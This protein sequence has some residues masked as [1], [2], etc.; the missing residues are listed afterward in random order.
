M[1]IGCCLTDPVSWVHF[2]PGLRG[3]NCVCRML[4]L[5]GVAC[6]RRWSAKAMKH[7]RTVV[8]ACSKLSTFHSDISKAVKDTEISVDKRSP[9]SCL[10]RLC[11]CLIWHAS[12]LAWIGLVRGLGWGQTQSISRRASLGSVGLNPNAA[13]G[14]TGV[15]AVS[16]ARRKLSELNS[17]LTPPTLIRTS[18][19]TTANV[20]EPNT[21]L[22]R[23]SA[24]VYPFIGCNIY[25]GLST[26]QW[27]ALEGWS[28]CNAIDFQKQKMLQCDDEFLPHLWNVVVRVFRQLIKCLYRGLFVVRQL[29]DPTFMGSTL[30][31]GLREA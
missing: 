14:A 29:N 9:S 8:L 20:W 11:D 1:Y 16:V 25:E 5:V 23:G 4:D 10:L 21:V 7:E 3:R 27:P 15:M 31:N 28:K 17:S 30:L 6:F 19:P 12:V 2:W 18:T 24:R 26:D 13:G 22:I